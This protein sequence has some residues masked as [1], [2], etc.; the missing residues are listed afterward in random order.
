MRTSRTHHARRAGAAAGFTLVEVLIAVSI[1]AAITVVVWASVS[2][3][4]E[5]RDFMEERYERFQIV[6]LSMNRM[7]TEIGGAYVAGAAH[8]GEPLPG[9]EE[10]GQDE[11]EE[12]EGAQRAR[13]NYREPVQFGLIGRADRIDFTSFSHVRTIEGE[14]A[15]HHAEIGYFVRRGRSEDGRTVSQLM[16][17][18]DT[19]LDDNITRGGTIYVMV[20][21]IESIKFEYWDSGE[22]QLGTTKEIAQ[23]RWVSDWDTTR[24]Q[25]AGRLPPRVR[26]TMVL[27]PQ[28]PRGLK[29]SFTTQTQIAMTEVLE[30]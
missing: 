25:F 14:R 10:T 6:R 21:E 26:I 9:E 15:S 28:G 4:F 2:N 11:E 24:R 19:T 5:T 29:E 7:A 12:E 18:S 1:M 3:M 22:V 8:G 16:R 13:R 27:P 20:P 30:F 17:R 23:G